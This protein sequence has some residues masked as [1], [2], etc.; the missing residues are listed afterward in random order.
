[1]NYR[2]NKL[3]NHVEIEILTE[4]LDTFVVPELKTEILNLCAEGFKYMVFDL[5]HVKYC[6]SSGLSVI[7]IANRSCKNEG[8]SFAV[9]SL[10][11]MVE[12]LIHISQLHTILNIAPTL[13]EAVDMLFIDKIGNE[14][15]D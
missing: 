13:N 3:E 14:L 7:L 15:N 12:K 10:Q 8:G 9:C 2:V 5:N 6:D 11:A 1:M 4:K